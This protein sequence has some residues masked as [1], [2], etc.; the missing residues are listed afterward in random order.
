ME[1]DIIKEQET[2]TQAENFDEDAKIKTKHFNIGCKIRT[3]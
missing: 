3:T 2:K 1:W